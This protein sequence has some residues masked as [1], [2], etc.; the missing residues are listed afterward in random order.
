M[1]SKLE[2][3]VDWKSSEG[4]IERHHVIPRWF[5]K[6]GIDCSRMEPL[7]MTKHKKKHYWISINIKRLFCPLDVCNIYSGRSYSWFR[8]SGFLAE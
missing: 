4:R 6:Y 5:E 7:P 2:V 8:R 1:Q 3:G